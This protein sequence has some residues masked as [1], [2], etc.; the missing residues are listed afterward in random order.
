M[1]ILG[2]KKSLGKPSTGSVCFVISVLVMFYAMG[3]N[4]AWNGAMDEG[5]DCVNLL[6]DL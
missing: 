4:I 5:N 2:S 6:M 3:S 1:V